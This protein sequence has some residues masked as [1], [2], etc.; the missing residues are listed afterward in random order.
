MSPKCKICNHHQRR[1]IELALLRGHS[2]RAISQQFAVSHGVVDRHVKHVSDALKHARE[3]MEVEHG[4]SL[5]V[6]LRELGSQ[7]QYLGVRAER[8]GD[9]RSAL[10]ALR[11][12]TRILELEARLTG[13]LNEKPETKVLNLNFDADTARRIAQTF[14]AR[15]KGVNPR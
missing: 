15:Y 7:A 12:L 5:L 13:E 4:K 3:L 6:Q 8:T 9:L 11:E 10:T 14:L 2:H 1:Q